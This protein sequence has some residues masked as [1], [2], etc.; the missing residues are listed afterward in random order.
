MSSS[1]NNIRF[2][3]KL[4]NP[5]TAFLSSAKATN[6]DTKDFDQIIPF[7]LGHVEKGAKSDLRGFSTF[8]KKEGLDKWLFNNDILSSFEGGWS[9]TDSISSTNL[10]RLIRFALISA[11]MQNCNATRD[12]K[13]LRYRDNW[14]ESK[15]N[16]ST[17]IESLSHTFQKIK[18][19]VESDPITEKANIINGDCRKILESDKLLDKFKLCITSPPY[20]NTFDYTDIYRPELFLGKFITSAQQ[21]YDLRL[22]TVRSHVQAKWALPTSNDFGVPYS[23]VMNHINKN[24][25]NLMH[26]EIP[27]MIQAYFEDMY[28]ILKLLKSRAKKNAQVWFVVSNSAYAD[29][30]IPVDLIIG[31]I[32]TKAGWFLKE[33]GVLRYVQKRKTKYSPNITRLRESVIILSESI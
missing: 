15:K 24:K 33:I 18:T 10:R 14:Q 30:E 8:S 19:D 13:C 4:V 29:M 20:L 3:N 6:A 17:F 16:K 25:E 7:I 31:D 23:E 22:K 11:A 1:I 2:T 28:N 27:T 32:G 26:K 12:G 21:L 9:Y 5:F